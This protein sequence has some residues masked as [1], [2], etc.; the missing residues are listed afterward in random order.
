M[1]HKIIADEFVRHT[2]TFAGIGSEYVTPESSEVLLQPLIYDG[3]STWGKGADR[4]FAAFLDAAENMEL[5]D[6]ETDSEVYRRGIALL[7][8]LQDF[9]SPEAMYAA[10]YARAQE[11]LQTGKFPTFFGG[12]HSVSIG[13]MQ[14]VQEY[15]EDV[16]ILQIDAH[17][18]LRPSYL[19]TPYNHACALHAANERGRVVQVG[20][21]SMDVS[22]RAHMHRERTFFA[23]EMAFNHDWMDRAVEQ[24]TDQVYL[25]FDLDAFDSALMPGTGT[26]EPG[27]LDWNTALKFLR[28]VFAAREVVGFDIVELLPIEGLLAPQYVAAKL[29]YK[30]LSYKFVTL[31]S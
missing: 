13:P 3:T 2:T 18:D 10:T 20:I 11:V 16:T 31:S 19:G 12:E 24:L 21:R 8:P 25:T 1:A 14:A 23:H 5:Y 26:P 22:E 4:G 17:A 28:K 30:M 15:F 7:D 6:I 27:G 29:Y 9:D